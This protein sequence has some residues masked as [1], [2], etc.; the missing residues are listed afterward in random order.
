[1]NYLKV[2]DDPGY[3]RDS[4]NNGLLNVDNSGLR[5]YKKQ[6]QARLNQTKTINDLTVDVNQ[7]KQDMSEIKDLLVKIL[8]K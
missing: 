8:D 1:M 4:V 6:K 3:V 2:K 7:L 5:A